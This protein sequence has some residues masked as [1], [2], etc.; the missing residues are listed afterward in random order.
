MLLGLL[1][2]LLVPGMPVVLDP[3]VSPGLWEL[4]AEIVLIVVLFASTTK[5]TNMA[6]RPAGV[7]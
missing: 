7:T 2:Y 3:T 4:T 1:S 6:A 5:R